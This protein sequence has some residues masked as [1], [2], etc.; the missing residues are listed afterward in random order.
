MRALGIARSPRAIRL[1]RESGLYVPFR[2]LYEGWPAAERGRFADLR[3]FRRRDAPILRAVRGD[4]S[5]PRVLFPHMSPG[6]FR[7]W[8]DGMLAKTLELR[9]CRPVFVIVR[10]DLWHEEYLR[11]FGF[12]D[13]VFAE[14]VM[15]D[16]RGHEARAA[17]MLAGCRSADDLLALRHEGT[18]IGRHAASR[19]LRNLRRASL[20]FDDPE[21]VAALRQ[22]LAR[23]IA[24]AIA[25]ERVLDDF[26][27]SLL[28]TS[29]QMYTPWAEFFDASLR[30]GVEG[31]YWYRSHLEGSLLVRRYVYENRHE[32]FFTLTDETWA[33]LRELPRSEADGEAF[34]ADLREG[35]ARGTWFERKFNLTQKRLKTPKEVRADLGLDPRK[36]T[37]FVFSHILYDATFWFGENLFPDYGGWLVETVKAAVA[38]PAVEWVIKLH[39]ENVLRAHEAKERYALENLEEVH[40]LRAAVGEVPPHVKLMTPEDDTSTASLFDVADYAL[41]VRG[42]VGLEFPCFGVPTLTAGTGGYS[43]RGFTIDSATPREY[44]DRLARIQDVPRLSAEETALAQRFSHGVFRL[45]PFPVTSFGWKRNPDKATD[46][47]SYYDFELLARSP[48]ELRAAPD[49]ARLADWALAS[50]RRELLGGG[51][52]AAALEADSV[53]D[54]MR[55]TEDAPSLV[56]R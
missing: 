30:R 53:E 27:P 41:T 50:D 14:D 47:F 52:A 33:E 37:A 7:T 40:L 31:I 48:E 16:S 8:V 35:Y 1:L 46:T 18:E 4:S 32:H 25:A 34:L 12:R 29:D 43:G 3:A 26:R 11:G 10:D 36:K 17:G 45:K 13:F 6:L 56:G 5:G 55:G 49:L 54:V 42:T 28:V 38:N 22:G 21:L 15:P 2:L 19:V 9:G 44:L 24:A 23:S 20:D 39:P 51:Q